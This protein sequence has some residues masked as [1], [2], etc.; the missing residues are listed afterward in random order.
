MDNEA[1][2]KFTPRYAGGGI[3]AGSGSAVVDKCRIMNNRA[4]GGGG[5]YAIGVK[6]RRSV[7]AGNVALSAK[8]YPNIG[9]GGGISASSKLE[10]SDSVVAGNFSPGNGGGLYTPNGSII[11]ERCT[12]AGNVAGNVRRRGIRVPTI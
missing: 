11:A 9:S 6:V 5:I 1:S 12:V 3:Y 2:G 7:I 10:I 4:D 8:L